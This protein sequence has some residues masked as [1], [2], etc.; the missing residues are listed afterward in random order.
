VAEQNCIG[1]SALAK[2]MQLVFARSE[3]HRPEL[4]RRDLAVG[5]HGE[6]GDY[7]WAF[8][9]LP[10]NQENVQRPTSNTQRSIV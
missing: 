3:I 5:G 8:S 9:C 1:L 6:G 7:E 10:H 2:Q 4:L